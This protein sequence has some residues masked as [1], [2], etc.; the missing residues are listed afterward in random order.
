MV[1]DHDG[2]FLIFQ[3]FPN[4]S[5]YSSHIT[6]HGSFAKS[7]RESEIGKLVEDTWHKE[8]CIMQGKS[9]TFLPF[10][11]K[12]VYLILCVLTFCQKKEAILTKTLKVIHL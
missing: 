11:H 12:N 1:K 2:S 7:F 9:K 4:K 8:V 5:Q 10:I 6:Q 3:C